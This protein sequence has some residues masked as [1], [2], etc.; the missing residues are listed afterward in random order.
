MTRRQSHSIKFTRVPGANQMPPAVRGGLDLVDDLIELMNRPAFRRAPVT[1]L[2][3]VD[4]TE[5]T[6]SIGPFIPDANAV[7]VEIR[8]IRVS[9]NKPQQLINHG[10]Q[11][12]LLG[13]QEWEAVIQRIPRLGTEDGQRS[14]SRPIRFRFSSLEN[15]PQKV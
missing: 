8:C 5:V 9:A 6:V 2:G 7:F 3:S 11:V 4:T 13:R 12:N 1:S 14:R 10:P 15:E